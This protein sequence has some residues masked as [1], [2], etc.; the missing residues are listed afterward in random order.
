MSK[1]ISELSKG[2]WS[3]ATAYT[4][5]DIVDY[6]GSSYI[7]IANTTNNVPPN[8]TYWALLA[9]K[10]DQ[11]IQGETGPQGIQGIPGTGEIP[12]GTTNNLVTINSSDQIQDS[13]VA[14]SSIPV[15]ATGAE[16]DTGTDDAK[17]VTAKA[18]AD[19]GYAKEKA[20]GAE[21]NT[22]TDDAKFVTAKAIEDSDYVKSSSPTFTGIVTAPK[23]TGAITTDSDGA[24]ITMDMSVSRHQVIMEGNRTLALTNLSTGQVT[25]VDLIQDSTGSRVPVM[26][27]FGA[28]VTMTIATPCVVTTSKDIPTLTPVIFTTTGALPTG[29]TA[30]TVYYYVRVNATTG[31]ISTSVANAQAGTYIA[32]SGSQSGTHTC[33]V[34]IRWPLQT[35]PTLSAGKFTKDRVNFYCLDATNTVVEGQ[36]AGQF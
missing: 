12:G 27:S 8:A 16:V 32:S 13:G 30:S 21:V 9:S 20:T 34:Q 3:E 35:T 25:I 15:K 23:I 24:T 36:V 19:S 17:Y 2:T 5:G 31:N 1:L 26:P 7:C 28:T 6:S 22:G 4:I 14:V 10:G 18:M 11:G 29:V 33:A